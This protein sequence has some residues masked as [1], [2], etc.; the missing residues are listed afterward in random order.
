MTRWLVL[1]GLFAGCSFSLSGPDPNRP[2][3]K[4]PDCSTGKTSVVVDGLFAAVSGVLAI[5][6]ASQSN[7]GAAAVAPLAVGALFTGAAIHGNSVVNDCRR[8]NMEYYAETAPG[9]RAP[10]ARTDT[11]VDV[12]PRALRPPSGPVKPV[13]APP[14]EPDQEAEPDAPQAP[15]AKAQIA[16]PAPGSPGRADHPLA[17]AKPQPAPPASDVWSNFWKE[18]R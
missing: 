4:S 10:I 8:A 17:P 16:P 15:V 12:P 14:A 13:A 11:E 3:G 7:S 9:P 18:V 6:L 1:L 2:R 5:S